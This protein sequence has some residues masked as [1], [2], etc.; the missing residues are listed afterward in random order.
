VKRGNATS[1]SNFV[2]YSL[3]VPAELILRL[4]NMDSMTTESIL[5]LLL[6][7]VVLLA[8]RNIFW[9]F[10]ALVGFLVGIELA[11]IWLAGRP[12]WMIISAAIVMGLIGAVLSM[13]YERV[14]FALAGFYAAGYLAIVLAAK[15]GIDTVT[16]G[17]VLTVGL[18]GA[19]LAALLMDGAII[20]LSSLAG[21]AAII[22]T[23]AA[24]PAVEMALFFVL[25]TIGVLVQWAVISRRGHL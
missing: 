23:I 5:R 10:I 11:E 19:L 17:V 22:S 7:C 13:L 24:D 12:I 6:G 3:D 8:G 16:V 14:A 20:V 1:K 9:L 4:R 15:L 18:L 21:A 25:V 2:P